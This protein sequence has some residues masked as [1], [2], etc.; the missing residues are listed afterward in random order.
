MEKGDVKEYMEINTKIENKKYRTSRAED[1]IKECNKR[2]PLFGLLHRAE[3]RPKL[4]STFLLNYLRRTRPSYRGVCLLIEN[5]AEANTNNSEALLLACMYC[6][7]RTVKYLLQKGARINSLSALF[8][9]A[10]KH[11]KL[12]IVKFL[13]SLEHTICKSQIPLVSVEN[14]E[15]IFWAIH[16]GSIAMVKYL[17]KHGADIT[18]QNGFAL[19]FSV[20]SG[21][22]DMTKYILSLNRINV[23]GDNY[24]TFALEVN[25]DDKLEIIIRIGIVKLLIEHGAIASKSD[26][27]KYEKLIGKKLKT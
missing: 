21:N 12:P 14:N 7:L 24:V 9:G 15:P 5:G 16:R 27:D 2:L 26:R 10:C 20:C 25:M 4:M 23:K 1:Y 11:G 13:H 18:V 22:I 8:I 19:K 3:M 6:S 17:V